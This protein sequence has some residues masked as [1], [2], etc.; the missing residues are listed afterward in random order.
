MALTGHVRA[1]AR[2]QFIQGERLRDLTFN[3]S[4]HNCSPKSRFC[5][6]DSQFTTIVAARRANSVEN[7]H[8]TAVRA[9]SQCR[10]FNYVM[11]TTFG[12]TGVALSSF[13]MC[14]VALAILVSASKLRFNGSYLDA[15]ALRSANT[16]LVF[17]PRLK[18]AS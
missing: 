10:C 6:F 7:M 4:P 2:V 3:L 15:L 5:V 18:G 1:H 9:Y 8:C 17:V 11:G 14:H 12:L 13:R 16:A